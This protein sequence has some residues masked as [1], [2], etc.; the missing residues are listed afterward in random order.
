MKIPFGSIAAG[1]I[2]AISIGAFGHHMGMEG[3]EQ[4]FTGMFG[5][6]VGSFM[7]ETMGFMTIVLKVL[8]PLR[9]FVQPKE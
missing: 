3:W 1:F 4:Y 7:I 9:L 8:A 6:M 2:G 5:F